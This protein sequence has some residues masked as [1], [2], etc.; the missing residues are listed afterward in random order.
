MNW[1]KSK[2]KTKLVVCKNDPWTKE[3][4]RAFS[5]FLK[6]SLGQNFLT[7]LNL[8]ISIEQARACMPGNAH[9]IERVS[10][11]HGAQKLSN[12]I[13]HLAHVEPEPQ[14]ND[15]TDEELDNLVNEM[16]DRGPVE[17]DVL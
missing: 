9:P 4:A 12:W 10:Q 14:S 3:S 7:Q 5:E 16:V 17:T 1:F 2:P 8:Y 11:A 15:L 6:G 13:L